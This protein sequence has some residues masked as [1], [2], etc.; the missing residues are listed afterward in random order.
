M[1]SRL[2]AD[3]REKLEPIKLVVLDVDGVLTDGSLIYSADGEDRKRFSARDGLAIRLL[4]KAGIQV[5]I[6]SGRSSEAVITRCSELGVRSELTIVGSNDKSADLDRMEELLQIADSEIAAMG[7]DLPD[8]PLLAR[9]GFAAC[10]NDAAPEVIAA[11]DLVCGAEGGRGA[12]REL[13]EVVLKGQGR[14]IEL[15]SDWL[16]P[17]MQ[18][19]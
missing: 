12:V 9:A 13:A 6:I 8:L 2:P 19:G 14:W 16:T 15:V 10:P 17:G 18:R 7:D 4:L 3:V 1:P 11:C 5:G